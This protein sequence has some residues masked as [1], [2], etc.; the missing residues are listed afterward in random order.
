MVS[1]IDFVKGAY[2]E[3]TPPI[4]R[5]YI[6]TVRRGSR[7]T[8]IDKYKDYESCY[9]RCNQN[10]GYENERLDKSAAIDFWLCLENDAIPEGR[11]LLVSVVMSLMAKDDFAVVDIGG[12]NN[13]AIRWMDEN[14]RNKIDYIVV[15]RGELVN[16][17]VE[18]NS[19]SFHEKIRFV[20]NVYELSKIAI[21]S[22]VWFGSS[23]QY[24]H[25]YED[26]EYVFSLGCDL[27]AIADSVFTEFEYDVWVKQVNVIGCEF[28][29]KWLSY[30]KFEN[31]AHRF[32]YVVVL[33]LVTIEDGVYS[34]DTI[35]CNDYCHRTI[36]LCNKSKI[37]DGEL[38]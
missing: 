4:V 25:R 3:W 29:N 12:G 20:K 7:H 22:L 6:N 31:M 14:N 27:I 24:V 32:N 36:V 33:N 1:L 34:H 18:S 21:P 38:F 5:R 15:D 13:P 9:S 30:S 16:E 11:E 17:I 26:I 2:R 8:Y 10:E 28:P 23:V 35:S 37:H 19:A